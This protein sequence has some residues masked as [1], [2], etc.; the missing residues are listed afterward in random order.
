MGP[1]LF[2]RPCGGRAPGFRQP[3]L[4]PSGS[5]DA[6]RRP[7][8]D[9]GSRASIAA[10]LAPTLTR[11][12]RTARVSPSDPRVSDLRP[13]RSK[14]G[15]GNNAAAEM[16]LFNNW[17]KTM[18]TAPGPD[19]Q[20]ETTAKELSRTANKC[21]KEEKQLKAKVK[22]A[23]EKGNIEGAKIHATDA[24]RKK[25]EQLNMLLRRGWT[26]WCPPGHPGEDEQGE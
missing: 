14:R 19:L 16:G 8:P 1:V 12:G 24:I 2:F 11:R 21:A 15:E 5:D 25:N 18:R 4:S 20:L 17:F 9:S 22:T 6:A 26:A 13:A 3:R 23:I 7:R 10:T